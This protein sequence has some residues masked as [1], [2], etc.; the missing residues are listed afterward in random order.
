[1]PSSRP[2]SSELSGA[3]ELG[4]ARTEEESWSAGQRL[5][6]AGPADEVVT[7]GP[8]TSKRQHTLHPMGV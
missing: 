6:C 7:A 1:M 3:C 5:G 8:L 4:G 2:P